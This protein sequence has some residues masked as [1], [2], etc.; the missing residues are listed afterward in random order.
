MVYV[1]LKEKDDEILQYARE[2]RSM[3][4]IPNKEQQLV[5]GQILLQFPRWVPPNAT[6]NKTDPFVV[7]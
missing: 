5:V 1:E 3:F 6:K 4:V 2:R 7:V